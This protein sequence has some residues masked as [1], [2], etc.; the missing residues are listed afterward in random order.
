MT[1]LIPH[2]LQ[3]DSRSSLLLCFRHVIANYIT[4]AYGYTNRLVKIKTKK[5]LFKCSAVEYNIIVLREGAGVLVK[6]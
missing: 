3:S 2:D 5:K 6:K 4:E 1:W